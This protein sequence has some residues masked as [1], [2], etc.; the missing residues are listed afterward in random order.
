[1]H[2]K[3][4][5]AEELVIKLFPKNPDIGWGFDSDPHLVATDTHYRH[6]HRVSHA[7]PFVLLPGKYEHAGLR[8]HVLE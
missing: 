4:H 2:V 6:N 7:N 8:S 1:M 5:V 3:F